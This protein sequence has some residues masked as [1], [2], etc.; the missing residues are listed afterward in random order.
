LIAGEIVSA[1]GSQTVPPNVAPVKVARV[2]RPPNWVSRSVSV[3]V[4]GQP[5]G[6]TE[7]ITDVSE[8][9]IKQYDAIFPQVVAR[10]VARRIVKKG[11]VYGAKEMSGI[12]KGS[13][14]GL[15]V[16]LAGIAWEATESA[17]TRCW[18]L[19]PD[20]IQVL[21]VELPAGQHEVDLQ[22]LV[23]LNAAGHR[24]AQSVEIA[25]GRNTYLLA[26]VP[27]NQV[28]GQVLV[29]RP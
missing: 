7:T 24:Q 26:V 27:D 8:L 13:F 4:D 21:R 20:T 19:L 1:V 12:Q 10:A 29:S 22:P 25:N 17:D 3:A 2:V 16:D 11:A 5:V 6:T 14:T 28:V 15:A 9:A 18:G 23:S